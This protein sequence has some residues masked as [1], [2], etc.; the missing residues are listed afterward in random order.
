MTLI[1]LLKDIQILKAQQEIAREKKFYEE[2]IRLIHNHIEALKKQQLY[3][4]KKAQKEQETERY[5]NKIKK[6]KQNIKKA[7]LSI[8]IDKRNEMESKRKKHCQT[9]IKG[10]RGDDKFKSKKK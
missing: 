8:E 7:L 9:K 5:K 4:S 1:L 6:E 2:K 3:L 10:K